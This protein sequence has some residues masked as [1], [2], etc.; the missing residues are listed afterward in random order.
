[1]CKKFDG[2]LWKLDE[3]ICEDSMKK[4]VDIRK[5]FLKK[6]F[7]KSVK[8]AKK[9]LNFQKKFVKISNK[10][11]ENF[12]ENF[13]KLQKNFTKISRKNCEKFDE[14]LLETRWKKFVKIRWK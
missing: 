9:K 12:T 8:F 1:M 14:N 10:N 3:K 13:W 7:K 2:N 6:N 4:F 11:S 5:S